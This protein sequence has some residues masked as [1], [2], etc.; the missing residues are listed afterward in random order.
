MQTRDQRREAIERIRAKAL[1]AE[2]RARKWCGMPIGLDWDK[3]A[4]SYA[5]LADKMSFDLAR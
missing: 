4:K 5:E 1:D 3:I 2:Q